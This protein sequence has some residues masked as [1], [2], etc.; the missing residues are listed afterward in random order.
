M[1]ILKKVINDF[2]GINWPKD[3]RV[4]KEYLIVMTGTFIVACFAFGID[5][6]AQKIL[7]LF[8]TFYTNDYPNKFPFHYPTLYQ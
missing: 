1:K 6:L 2:K 8:Y 3:T 5:I 4:K 7:S